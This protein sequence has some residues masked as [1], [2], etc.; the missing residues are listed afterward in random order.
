MV[1]NWR[2]SESVRE[3]RRGGRGGAPSRCRRAVPGS[4]RRRSEQ[5]REDVGGGGV[6]ARSSGE[7]ESSSCSCLLRH[8]VCVRAVDECERGGGE[9][10]RL[11]EDMRS[12][13]LRA[14]VAAHGVGED[15]GAKRRVARQ[16]RLLVIRMMIFW[17]VLRMWGVGRCVCACGD[18]GQCAHRSCR[19]GAERLRQGIARRSAGGGRARAVGLESCL[20]L[21][22]ASASRRPSGPTPPC[23]ATC[24][25]RCRR[26]SRGGGA[27]TA[28][29]QLERNG[30]RGA[31]G[32]EI[33]ILRAGGGGGIGREL[34]QK[35]KSG[36]VGP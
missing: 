31:R 16:R 13:R 6:G 19:R 11:R 21:C 8:A 4:R 33:W 20:S 22:P 27:Q 12:N 24:R 34:P 23:C 9:L 25:R 30:Q 26:T 7:L 18:C 10:K 29:V 2:W 3:R 1:G 35:T 36:V 32:V 14:I 17:L 15:V 28:C 5:E